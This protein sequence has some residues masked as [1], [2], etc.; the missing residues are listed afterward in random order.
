MEIKCACK[1]CRT[2]SEMHGNKNAPL[3]YFISS[4]YLLLS[5]GNGFG[6]G[7]VVVVV[8]S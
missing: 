7:V 2:N 5:Q 4:A 1:E 3:D 8:M 6:G